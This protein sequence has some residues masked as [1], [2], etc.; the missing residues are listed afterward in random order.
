MYLEFVKMRNCYRYT[1]HFTYFQQVLVR[2]GSSPQE[3]MAQKGMGS[4]TQFRPAAA[5]AA[6]SGSVYKQNE[7]HRVK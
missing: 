4:L 7:L 3:S 6:M 5:I 2:K 1:S